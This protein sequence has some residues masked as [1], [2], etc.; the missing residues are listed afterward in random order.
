MCEGG[1]GGVWASVLCVVAISFLY[2]GRVLEGEGGRCGLLLEL[3]SSLIECTWRLR[4][5]SRLF[6]YMGHAR[7]I[8]AQNE[9]E[10]VKFFITSPTWIQV[11]K[12]QAR[13]LRRVRLMSSEYGAVQDT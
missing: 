6:V 1:G 9:M 4:V 5:R 12:K 2:N 7:D 3:F 13:C 10:L 11:L 8:F